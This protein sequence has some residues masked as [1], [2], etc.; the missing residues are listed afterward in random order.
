[1]VEYHKNHETQEYI[2]I[3]KYK[4]KNIDVVHKKLKINHDG[5]DRDGPDSCSSYDYYIYYR[6]G[7]N[8]YIDIWRRENCYHEEDEEYFLFKYK[9]K[10]VDHTNYELKRYLELYHVY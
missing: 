7:Y 5:F 3:K 10:H 1:M 2:V 9:M 8:Y 4:R 6:I